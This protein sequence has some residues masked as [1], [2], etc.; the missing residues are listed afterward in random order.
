MKGEA[1]EHESAAGDIVIK[2]EP[3]EVDDDSDIDLDEEQY[4]IN[5]EAVEMNTEE[6]IKQETEDADESS[7]HQQKRSQVCNLCPDLEIRVLCLVNFVV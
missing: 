4:C 3:V 5:N 2:N 7:S 1:G 6:S